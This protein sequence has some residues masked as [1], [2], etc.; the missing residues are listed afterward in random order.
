MEFNSRALGNLNKNLKHPSRIINQIGEMMRSRMQR[1]FAEQSRGQ[2]S[3]KA[4]GVPNI[5]GILSDLERTSGINKSRRFEPR[6]ALMD[7]SNLLKSFGKGKNNIEMPSKFKVDVGTPVEYAPKLNVG[8]ESKKDVTSGIKKNLGIYLK[9]L[10]GQAR[11]SVTNGKKQML[12]DRIKGLGWLFGRTSVTVKIP[13]RPFA[14]ITQQDM[15]D[16]IG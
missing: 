15:K 14:I 1:S 3:W 4:R 11:R 5:M 9:R 6:P 2:Y 13:A 7:T 10:R 16:M 12:N 8:G